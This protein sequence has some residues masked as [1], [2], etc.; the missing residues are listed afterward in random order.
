MASLVNAPVVAPGWRRGW[1]SVPEE[2]SELERALLDVAPVTEDSLA[3]S[4]NEL[5]GPNGDVVSTQ[6][7]PKG[8]QID[9][10]VSLI[11]LLGDER[12]SR[13][14][15]DLEKTMPLAIDCSRRKSRERRRN[16]TL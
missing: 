2:Q 3:R 4:G 12:Y 15:D 9:R 5:A 16:T 14:A 8:T 13:H 1:S 10:M 11:D 6:L 7:D